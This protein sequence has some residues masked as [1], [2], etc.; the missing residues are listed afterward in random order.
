MIEGK[1]QTTVL[2]LKNTLSNNIDV[3]M[4]L[5]HVAFDQNDNAIHSY[6]RE[7]LLKRKTDLK[8]LGAVHEAIP[9]KRKCSI[10]QYSNQSQKITTF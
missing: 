1:R 2:K 5:Y 9:P 4:L 6:Y 3:V 10:F 7:R 8:W